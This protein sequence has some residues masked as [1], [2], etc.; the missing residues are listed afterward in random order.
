MADAEAW[1]ALLARNR[2]IEEHAWGLRGFE[3]CP[4]TVDGAIVS[5]VGGEGAWIVGTSAT[6]DRPRADGFV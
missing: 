3:C 6:K 2:M 5:Y 1:K 4:H